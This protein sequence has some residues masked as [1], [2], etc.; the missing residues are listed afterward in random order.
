MIE[1]SSEP[2]SIADVESEQILDVVF[3]MEIEKKLLDP[4]GGRKD[5]QNRVLR[6]VDE[7]TF[8]E[9]PLRVLRAV[10]FVARF[11]LQPHPTTL[12]LCQQMVH[13]KLLEELPK[14]RIYK[15]F[16]KLLL[17]AHKPSL[18]LLLLKKLGALNYFKPLR[19][20]SQKEYFSVCDSLDTLQTLQTPNPQTHLFIAFALLCR[21]FNTQECKNF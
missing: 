2:E 21:F 8:Q 17:K 20:L 4:F 7:K 15:E 18:G 3:E 9:D 11:E 6:V 14:E 19:V 12:Q 10:Q 13:N 5:L 1:E 16:T